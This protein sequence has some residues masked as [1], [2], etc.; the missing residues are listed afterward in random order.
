LPVSG[1]AKHGPEREPRR[2]QESSQHGKTGAAHRCSGRRRIEG[3]ELIPVKSAMRFS[4]WSSARA[5]L[6]GSVVFLPRR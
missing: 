3:G 4:L 5:G 6:R 2:L 1:E